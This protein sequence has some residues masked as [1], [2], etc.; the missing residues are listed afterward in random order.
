KRD[1]L[2]SHNKP[3]V[4]GSLR[5]HLHFWREK[6]EASTHILDVIEH[7][8]KI[9]FRYNPPPFEFKNNKSALQHRNFVEETL[10]SL[11]EEEKFLK[12]R[13]LLLLTL[14][15][16]QSPSVKKRLIL[17]IS[18]L[19]QFLWKEKIKFD[20]WKVFEDFIDSDAEACL[21]K[22]DLKSGYHHVDIHC[23]HQK[24]LGFS[25]N[26]GKGPKRYFLY[27]VLPFGLSSGPLIFTKIVRVLIKFWRAHGIRI[28]CF[29]DDGLSIE[30]AREKAKE[31]AV[32]VKGSLDKSG[33]IVNEEKSQW[34]PLTKIQWL[35]IQVDFENKT[36]SIS[37]KRIASLL[38]SLEVIFDNPT[39]TS[40]RQLSCVAGKIVSTKFVLGNV[41][42]L[43]T[44]LIYK[45]IESR[46]SWDKRI[47]ITYFHDVLRELLFWKLN[48]R[49]LNRRPIRKY[50]IPDLKVFSD[51]SATG[52]GAVLEKSVCYRNL[53]QLEKGESSTFRELL[54]IKYAIDSFD[55]LLGEKT[56]LWHTDNIS[57]A[58]IVRIGSN[59][60]IFIRA[61]V[62]Q[63]RR[64]KR[65]RQFFH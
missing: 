15:Q 28:A 29:L 1:F 19:N 64:E 40:A 35:G 25:W 59:K 24:Y 21:F 16:W 3:R 11:L 18:F 52:I 5:R 60:D 42:R 51:A 38:K 54:A 27:S 32:F 13:D 2:L 26:F 34:E 65:K 45:L 61:E 55:E 33:F 44:R 37:E 57:T 48:V 53:K 46:V 22:F 63:G 17:D 6:L 58:I 30:Y 4:K 8:Y 23:D 31:N 12:S 20:N 39:R 36:Y 47:N 43:K 7:G 9:P 56:I 14:C 49:E 50:E 62:R 41:I 10:E